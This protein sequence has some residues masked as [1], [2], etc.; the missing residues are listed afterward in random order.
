[1]RAFR[2]RAAAGLC[3]VL[4]L[5]A[6]SV[7]VAGAGTAATNRARADI[8]VRGLL[9]L[10][11]LPA[12]AV[13][14]AAA[15]AA[16]AEIDNAGPMPSTPD[17]VDAHSWW[18]V[19]GTAK[20]VL[21]EV[22]AHP[23]AGASV[24]GSG[25]GDTLQGHT[26]TRTYFVIFAFP[27]RAGVL[28]SR[29]LIVKVVALSPGETA[30]RVDAEDVWEIPRAASERVPAGV[31]EIDVT[32]AVPGKPPTLS[33]SVTDA[34]KVAAIA[35][36]LDALPVVQPSAIECPMILANAPTVSLTFRAVAGG[37]ALAQATQLALPTLAAAT[38]C[39]P[40]DFTIGSARQPPLLAGSAFLTAVGKVVGR[41]LVGSGS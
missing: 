36:L 24:N 14:L 19:P 39:N 23:P 1:M 29:T 33:V 22:K 8:D 5:A 34:A 28:D 11:Q 38:P 41:P 27:A 7:A 17:L 35:K 31:H 21:A 16:A 40:V 30:V 37:P 2:L 13:R 25:G 32:R 26:T 6:G 9:V 10:E 18:R 20:A 3:A 15:P 4:A 12:G